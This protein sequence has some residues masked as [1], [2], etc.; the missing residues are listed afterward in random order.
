MTQAEIE[1]EKEL[2]RKEFKA[3]ESKAPIKRNS[4]TCKECRH[5]KTQKCFKC[6][7]NYDDKWEV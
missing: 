3:I 6:S 5:T 4:Q 7:R 2:V 1:F